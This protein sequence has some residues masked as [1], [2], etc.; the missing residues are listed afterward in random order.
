[1][2][3]LLHGYTSDEDEWAHLSTIE[4]YIEEY[5][6]VV[7]MPSLGRSTYVDIGD[8]HRYWTYLSEE[9]PALAQSSSPSQT[10][11]RIPSWPVFRWAGMALIN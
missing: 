3:Y 7:V 5:P 6:L 9:L 10:G 2:L 11:V 4:W 8:T 1:M